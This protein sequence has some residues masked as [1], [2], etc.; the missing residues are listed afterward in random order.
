MFTVEAEARIMAPPQ[1]Q[2][3]QRVAPTAAK[4]DAASS[5]TNNTNNSTNN[6]NRRTLLSLLVATGA[7]LLGVLTPPLQHHHLGGWHS[8]P[9]S[10]TQQQRPQPD[11]ER[12]LLTSSSPSPS[13]PSLLF[14]C[15]EE[16]LR[17]FWHESHVPGFHIVCLTARSPPSSSA[18]TTRTTTTTT[19]PTPT[20]RA[21]HAYEGG[22]RDQ[23]RVI[24][25]PDN[26]N[27]KDGLLDWS[28]VRSALTTHLHL[29]SSKRPRQAWALFTPLGERVWDEAS[30]DDE[31]NTDKTWH[32]VQ[33]KYETLLL[34]EG[35]QFLWPGVRIGFHR[36]VDLYSIMPP[37]SPNYSTASSSTSANNNT[38]KKKTV[39]LET[40]SLR[41]LVVSVQG[42]LSTDECQYIRDAAAPAMQYSGV[43]LMDHDQGRESSE[44]RTSQTA[45]LKTHTRNTHTN[46]DDVEPDEILLDMDY[47]TASLVRIPR[48]HQETV[49]VLRYGP[50]ERYTSHHDFFDPQL[51]QNDAS[52]LRLIQNGRRNRMVTVFWYLSDV[53]LG[54]ETIF[55]RAGGRRERSFDDCETGLKV[56]PETG[57]VIIFYSMMFDGTTDP[58]SLHGACP[59]KEGIKWAANKWVWNEPMNYVR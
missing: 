49:Q 33:S 22:V 23:Q 6:T 38:Q 30:T 43:V 34:Y 32:Q 9:W 20:V 31:D 42:F 8:P 26:D 57:K 44:F 53:A 18:T 39:T 24:V 50:T 58:S 14:P 5:S 28:L 2:Q 56:Q 59:V 29:S 7:F 36:T 45:F 37:G 1:Q 52:T 16:F 35:G 25:Q 51:Y 15:T 19:T 11:T 48:S 55:P 54:G 46:P 40:L 3:Q 13:P 41:P 17:D 4:P 27:E 12:S 47:R 10:S 21:V